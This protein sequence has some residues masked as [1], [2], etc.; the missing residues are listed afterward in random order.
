M[1]RAVIASLETLSPTRFA[2]PPRPTLEFKTPVAHERRCPPGGPVGYGEIYRVLPFGN[3]AVKLE[4]TGTQVREM[5]ERVP[6]FYYSNLDIV[7]NSDAPDGSRIFELR[8]ADGRELSD[9]A[10]YTLGIADFLAEGGGGLDML[11]TIPREPLGV[12]NLDATIAL[13]RNGRWPTVGQLV[14]FVDLSVES[15]RDPAERIYLKRLGS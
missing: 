1:T 6:G 13:T 5:I 8:F 7:L 12:T 10:M 14:G 11:A 4:L 9:D 2:M 15:A 3:E